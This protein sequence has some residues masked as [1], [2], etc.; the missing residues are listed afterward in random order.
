MIKKDPPITEVIEAKMANNGIEVPISTATSAASVMAS[1]EDP[2]L[3]RL[4]QVQQLLLDQQHKYS[5]PNVVPHNVPSVPRTF[6][7]PRIPGSILNV[8]R[9]P[10]PQNVLRILGNNAEAQK[11][12]SRSAQ[13]IIRMRGLPYDATSKQVVSFIS[14]LN[15]RIIH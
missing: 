2:E 7:Y 14:R 10:N 5:V 6:L 8:G 3:A 1:W 15:T 4:V 13:V 11:F 12:L 9:F